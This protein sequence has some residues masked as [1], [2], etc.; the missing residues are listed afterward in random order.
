MK[1]MWFFFLASLNAPALAGSI[2]LLSFQTP[3]KNQGNF[4]HCAFYATTALLEGAIKFT[5]GKEFDISEQ[6]EVH[7]SK[8]IHSQ[9]PE[10]EF[11]DTYQ[12]LQ[13]FQK[14]LYF[15]TEEGQ[16]VSFRGF[17]FQMLT[18]HWDSR[19]WSAI[20]ADQL[21]KQ[22]SVVITLKVAVPYVDDKTGVIVYNAEIDRKCAA[23][24]IPCGG[25]AVLLIGYNEEKK[26]FLF[27]NSWGPTWG[28]NGFGFVH[29]EHVDLYSDQPVTGYFDKLVSPMLL[30]Q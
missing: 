25:H 23:Q 21:K 22:R 12:L 6:F 11:G 30:D 28:E 24:E 18:K 3:A 29:A 8:V 10:V 13:N 17:K 20:I 27:K 2:Q 15:K 16:Q 9:R 4:D 7:R 14:D 5:F 26:I 1:Y 19:P